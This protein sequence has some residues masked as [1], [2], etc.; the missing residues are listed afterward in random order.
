MGR[1]GNIGITRHLQ[2]LGQL[3]KMEGVRQ[4]PNEL[5][6]STVKPTLDLG[7]GGW[8]E[9]SL[10][11]V[12][13]ELASIA[14]LS[15]GTRVMISKNPADLPLILNNDGSDRRVV[16]ASH[17]INWEGNPGRLLSWRWY[18]KPNPDATAE[19][20]IAYAHRAG[21]LND[22]S[23]LQLWIPLWGFT[24]HITNGDPSISAYPSIASTWKGVVPAG[25][26]LL[27]QWWAWDVATGAAAAMPANTTIVSSAATLRS[28][29]GVNLP[30]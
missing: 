2:R 24:S 26:A 19:I 22:W 18:L 9:R 8:M 4:F 13:S 10:E 1:E 3:L 16:A 12:Q 6:F 27:W 11:G 25:W 17:R 30:T 20:D 21:Q 28:P 23:D 15:Q 29:A 14:G 5:D 7:Q